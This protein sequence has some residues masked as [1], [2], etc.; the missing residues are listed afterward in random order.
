M[1]GNGRDEKNGVQSRFSL[2]HCC[3]RQ[4]G[5]RMQCNA[6]LGLFTNPSQLFFTDSLRHD[7]SI[8]PIGRELRICREDHLPYHI[9]FRDR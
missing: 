4:G 2:P 9:F 1:P 8:I 7:N 3:T 6:A 5:V